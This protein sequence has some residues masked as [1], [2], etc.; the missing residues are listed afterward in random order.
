MPTKFEQIKRNLREH[1][2]TWLITGCSGFIG[3]NLLEA[4]LLLD[5]TVIGLDNFAT[6][7]RHNLEEICSLV[8]DEQ[9]QRFRFI[10]GDVPNP[11][12]CREACSGVDYVLHHAALGSVPLSIEDPVACTESNINGTLNM[13]VAARDC[14]V[15][16]FVYASS[17]A[18]YGD[19]PGLP[20]VEDSI[21]SFLSNYA[22]SKYVNELYAHQFA[23]H[24]G[25]EAVGLR[26]FNVFG[27]RQDPERGLRGGHTQVDR[28]HDC[29]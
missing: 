25:L 9:W 8:T 3:S 29:R 22:V 19:N 20:K 27:P 13:L 18:V 10:E 6:G 28:G 23:L 7:K 26:Y 17:S 14:G 4:L 16:R 2:K 1:P 5:Q 21:G 12:A 24:Y 15:K 11:E